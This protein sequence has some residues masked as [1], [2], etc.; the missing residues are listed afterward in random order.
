MRNK[1]FIENFKTL[2]EITINLNNKLYKQII[3]QRYLKQKFEQKKYQIQQQ[4]RQIEFKTSHVKKR[5]N[6]TIFIKFNAILFKNPKTKKKSTNKK[7]K[8]TFYAYDK[9]NHYIKN[10]KSKNIV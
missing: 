9:E 5:L 2:I 1:H 10:C 3:K 6:D 4:K 8:T 7:K